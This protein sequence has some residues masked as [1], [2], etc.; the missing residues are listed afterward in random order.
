MAKE[1][2]FTLTGFETPEQVRQR[3]GKTQM[4]E[5]MGMFGGGSFNDKIFAAAMGGGQM[6]GQG[7]AGA[8]GYESP[9]EKMAKNRQQI[10]KGID[11]TNPTD[12][13]TAAKRASEL[14]DNELHIK[15]AETYLKLLPNDVEPP[16]TRQVGEIVDGKNYIV[17]QQWDKTTRTFKEV[18]RRETSKQFFNLTNTPAEKAASSVYEEV[19]KSANQA[20][21]LRETAN[22]AGVLLSNIDTGKLEPIKLWS[23]EWASSLGVPIETDSMRDQKSFNATFKKSVLVGMNQQKGTASEGDRKTVEDAEAS[24]ADPKESNMFLINVAKGISNRQIEMANFYDQ[25][26][27]N[28]DGRLVG[29]Q[30]AWARRIDKIRLVKKDK[31]GLIR[32]YYDDKD[33]FMRNPKNIENAQRQRKNLSDVFD[34]W[35]SSN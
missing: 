11:F 22:Q 15:L 32:H 20:Y 12:I 14:G 19:L 35:W 28:N 16:K 26:A 10:L 9:E 2:A 7:I 17:D 18:G 8:L 27:I 33:M 23:K 29:A 1:G 30:S 34:E 4:A 13:V 24:L 25:W 5:T 6:I 3:I 31:N 21:A